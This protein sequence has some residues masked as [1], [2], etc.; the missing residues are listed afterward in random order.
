MRNRGRRRESV[1]LWMLAWSGR[2]AERSGRLTQL[3]RCT[4]PCSARRSGGAA[5]RDVPGARVGRCAVGLGDLRVSLNAL[6]C[7]DWR[8]KHLAGRVR[9]RCAAGSCVECVAV[10]ASAIAI[11]DERVSMNVSDSRFNRNLKRV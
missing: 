7:W 6:C 5:N 9:R 8:R 4:A 10:G 3:A 2:F 11:S 1:D